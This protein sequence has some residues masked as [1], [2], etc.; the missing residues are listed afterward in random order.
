MYDGGKK[1]RRGGIRVLWQEFEPRSHLRAR[2]LGAFLT[3]FVAFVLALLCVLSGHKRGYMESANLFTV[4]TSTL[5]HVDLK[6]NIPK[7]PSFPSK[8]DVFD[9]IGDTAA[10]AE[11]AIGNAVPTPV[12]SV[13]NTVATNVDD[14]GGAIISKVHS[15]EGALSTAINSAE[16]KAQNAL[17]SVIDELARKLGIHQWYSLHVMNWCEGYYKPG[18]I[19]NATHMPTKNITKCSGAKRNATFDLTDIVGKE[20]V[21]GISLSDL[22]WPDTIANGFRALKLAINVMFVFYVIGLMWVSLGLL[23][24]FV[25]LVQTQTRTQALINMTLAWVSHSLSSH[26]A[27][28]IGH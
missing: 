14:T 25:A 7:L 18:Y 27:M 13:A 21:P 11:S 17:N 9:S 10:V 22:H 12:K 4:N 15:A 19:A 8:R 16:T 24:V 28:Q 3:L 2:I 5:G 6:S 26:T 20:L 23:G 1:R